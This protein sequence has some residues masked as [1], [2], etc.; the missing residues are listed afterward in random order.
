MNDP[1]LAT[2]ARPVCI[3]IPFLT[4]IPDPVMSIKLRASHGLSFYS[5]S[6]EATTAMAAPGVELEEWTSLVPKSEPLTGLQPQDTP[7]KTLGRPAIGR[8]RVRIRYLPHTAGLVTVTLRSLLISEEVARHSTK[9]DIFVRARV[10]PGGS[11]VVSRLAKNVN[12]KTNRK[13]LLHDEAL[14]LEID[15]SALL[16]KPEG[17]V[18]SLEFSVFDNTEG[19]LYNCIGSGTLPLSSAL[20][21]GFT[22]SASSSSSFCRVL[23][24]D[25]LSGKGTGLNSTDVVVDA[26]GLD[27]KLDYQHQR[28][29]TSA[30]GAEDTSS[31][32][33]SL[34][35]ERV[36]NIASAEIHLKNLFYKLQTPGQSGV[37]KRALVSNI[38]TKN[39]PWGRLLAELRGVRVSANVSMR[40]MDLE[41]H[42][43][44]EDEDEVSCAREIDC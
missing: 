17:E 42:D 8:A 36:K 14:K 24:L 37:S 29:P 13:V 35:L 2:Q 3:P 33:Q 4:S 20:C 18:P 5:S 39:A 25:H 41:G 23:L 31:N 22:S 9:R 15:T 16:L 6:V 44:N 26:G 30:I 38:T 10:L 28:T 19:T 27:I 12:P 34:S 21:S 32:S 1:Q 7:A 43:F 40:V 11:W